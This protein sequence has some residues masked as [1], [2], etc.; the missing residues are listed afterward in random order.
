VRGWRKGG[1]VAKKAQDVVQSIKAAE[2][3]IAE[4]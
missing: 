2:Q 3:T 4:L 1:G